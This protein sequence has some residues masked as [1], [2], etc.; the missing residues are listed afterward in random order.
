MW[1]AIFPNYTIELHKKAIAFLIV[2]LI[3][4]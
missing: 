3:K 1:K 2:Y 4:V